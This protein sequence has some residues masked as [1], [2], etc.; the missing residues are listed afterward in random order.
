MVRKVYLKIIIFSSSYKNKEKK[1]IKVLL[2][3]GI[4]IEN[5]NKEFKNLQLL[6]LTLTQNL[7]T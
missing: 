6:L 1:T 5:T 2:D 7:K 4:Y 3:I